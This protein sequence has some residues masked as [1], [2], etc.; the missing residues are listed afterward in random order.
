MEDLL[1]LESD[2][3]HASRDVAS[4]IQHRLKGNRD[5]SLL[6]QLVDFYFQTYSK[7][8]RKI[9]TTLRETHS[10][11]INSFISFLLAFVL[12]ER[13]SYLVVFRTYYSLR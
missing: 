6:G 9:L 3:T 2:D 11:V 8:A 5:P 4:R 7:R 1:K 12:S 10:Q 13:W